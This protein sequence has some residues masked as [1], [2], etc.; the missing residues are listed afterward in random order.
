MKNRIPWEGMALPD[1]L[2]GGIRGTSGFPVFIG[3][4]LESLALPQQGR[5]ETRFPLFSR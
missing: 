3:T 4:T 5:G 1:P 2:A